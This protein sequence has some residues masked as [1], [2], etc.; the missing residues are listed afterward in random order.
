MVGEV[1]S[2][3]CACGAAR[4]EI[5]DEPIFVN[6]C[7]CRQCQQQTGSTSVLNMFVEMEKLALVSGETTRH[8]VKAG[9]GGDHVIVRCALCGTALWSHYPRLGELGAGVRVGTL[10]NPADIRP[11]AVIYTA[12]KMEWL[13]LPPGIP[14]FEANYNPAELL[15]PDR[16]A[17]LKAL[18]A[19]A[20]PA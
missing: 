15:P 9:S 8:V 19:K 14:A 12:E 16:F 20:R 3:G 10:D 11:D 6:N 2:G 1:R 7:H 18:A 17:R 4:Y 5:K 13:A